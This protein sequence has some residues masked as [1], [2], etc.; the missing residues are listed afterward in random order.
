MKDLT[1]DSIIALD[2]TDNGV[3]INVPDLSRP[4]IH[5]DRKLSL[6]TTSIIDSRKL[7]ID[8]NL[9]D[10]KFSLDTVSTIFYDQNKLNPTAHFDQTLHGNRVPSQMLSPTP[11]ILLNIS[12][13]TVAN[14]SSNALHKLNPICP[15]F[16]CCCSPDKTSTEEKQ[17]MSCWER[18][19]FGAKTI[20]EHKWFDNI[21]LL[22][23]FA[24]SFVLVSHCL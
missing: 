23:I 13:L 6:D 8:T 17:E 3:C 12:K 2:K 9:V 11:S 7:S 24:S 4:N 20:I 15:N 21:I 14:Q 5:E 19:R 1:S 22:L 16:F 18:F 10:R